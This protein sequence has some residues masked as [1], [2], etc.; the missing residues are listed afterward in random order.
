MKSI[1]K[2]FFFLFLIGFTTTISAQKNVRVGI[3]L[4][5][6]TQHTEV[7]LQQL[8]AEIKAV[9]GEDAFISFKKRT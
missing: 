6:K 1:K 8:K 9:I 3:T 4:D 2:Y 5:K 7:L